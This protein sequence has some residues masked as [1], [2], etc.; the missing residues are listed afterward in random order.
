VSLAGAAATRRPRVGFLGVGWIGRHRMEHMLAT[1]AIDA[2]A[3]ADPSDEMVAGAMKL[4]PDAVRVADLDA[5][6]AQ[7]LDGVVIATPSAL[8][9]GQSI[10][11]LQRGMAVFCQKPLG[12]SEAECRGVLDA[13]RASDRL[14]AVDMSYRGTDGLQRIKSLAQSGELG[15]IHFIDLTFHNAYG[16]DKDWFYDPAQSGGGCLTDLGVHLVDLALWLSGSSTVVDVASSLFCRGERLRRRDQV[17]DLA[18]AHLTL[19]SGCAVRI[20][21]S[22]RISAGQDARIEMAVHGT[23]GAALMRNVNGSFYDFVTERYRGT[24][25][26]ELSSY[27]EQWGGRFAADWAVKLA[28][29]AGYD[30]AIE[31]VADVA[32]IIDRVYRDYD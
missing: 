15:R 28:A 8:H 25:R 24:S 22:W 21:C 10:A 9:A 7:D 32:A 13:A 19:A 1:G 14:L 26:E 3:V 29:G 23:D 30:P 6:L 4:A 11:A 31:S 17:E 5:M 2:A 12:R 16:P 27:P 18:L 20:A